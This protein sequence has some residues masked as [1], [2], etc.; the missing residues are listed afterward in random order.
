VG[1]V[2]SWVTQNVFTLPVLTIGGDAVGEVTARQLAP[3]TENLTAR[4][5]PNAGHIVPIDE[6][7]EFSALVAQHVKSAEVRS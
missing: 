5:L 2:T 3:I 1:Q 7:E 6:P 4:L